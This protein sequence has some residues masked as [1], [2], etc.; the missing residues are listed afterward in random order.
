VGNKLP[1]LRRS[2]KPRNVT[3]IN[4]RVRNSLRTA[5]ILT[6]FLLTQPLFADYQSGLDAYN[7]GNYKT[8]RHEWIA[9]IATPPG[10]VS[11]AIY[12]ETNYAIGMLYWMGQ[13][14]KNDYNQ[15]SNWIQKAA[16][17]NHAGA[18]A[19]LG[20]LYTQG[21]TVPQNY[22]T[23]FQWFSKAAKQGDIDGQYNLGIFYLNG[24][25][26][27]QNKTM[28]AQYL[29]AASAQGDAD[30][31]QALINL[32]PIIPIPT[33]NVTLA[34]ARTAT[35][36]SEPNNAQRHSGEGRDLPTP[37]EPFIN[38]PTWILNQNSTHYTI[39]VIG[40]RSKEALQDLIQNHQNL[41][42]YATYTLQKN[43]KPLHILIQGI[44]PTVESARQAKAQ[45]PTAI[46]PPK[47]VWIRKFGKIQELINSH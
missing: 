19:K 9:V 32:L 33:N 10:K 45:F 27:E 17:L 28:A 15:A 38:P 3:C 25:G 37:P 40:L 20:Y 23:A 41:T 1:T 18:Q 31:E 12:A 4:R 30:A 21:I 14:V 24:W 44:Y 46:Q 47:N 7:A 13:G 8:A 16:D 36:N 34:Q 11:P 26:T 42:P 6:I 5:L 39:Q 22:E 35:P 43:N 29:A 2:T